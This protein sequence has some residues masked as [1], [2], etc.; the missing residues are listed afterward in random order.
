MEIL[1][2]LKRFSE[3]VTRGRFTGQTTEYSIAVGGD[4]YSWNITRITHG[5]TTAPSGQMYFKGFCHL[6]QKLSQ[7]NIDPKDAI[8][9]ITAALEKNTGVKA[10][11]ELNDLI[12]DSDDLAKIGVCLDNLYECNYN[13]V[14]HDSGKTT[15]RKR[16]YIR[17][18]K[19]KVGQKD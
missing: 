5:K 9:K 19:A 2:E 11:D 16:V 12:K 1:C 18:L 17:V 14:A 7:F 3:K 13:K 8:N 15:D 10:T 6:L 4:N